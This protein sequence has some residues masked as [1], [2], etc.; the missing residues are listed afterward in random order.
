MTPGL[1]VCTHCRGPAARRCTGCL[2]APDYDEKP[3]APSFYCSIDC[4]KAEWPQHQTDCRKLQ[5]RKSLNR[6]ASL[7]QAI[8]YKIRM[9]TTVLQITS[10]HVEGTTIRLNG[11]QPSP[12]GT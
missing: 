4:Q 7:L 12:H 9:H 5:A 10:A 6:A 8:V 2:V 11:T 3:S 1:S